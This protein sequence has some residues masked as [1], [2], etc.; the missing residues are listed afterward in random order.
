MKNIGKLAVLGAVLAA[1]S[2]FAFADQVV[3]ASYGLTTGYNPGT[4]T[5]TGNTA[6]EFAAEYLTGST[7]PTGPV[8][9][10]SSFTAV[11]TES[12]DLNPQTPIWNAALSG[13]SW[14]G[15]ATTAGPSPSGGPNTTVNP[16]YGYYEFTT[17]LLSTVAAGELNVYADDTTEVLLYNGST[18]STLIPLGSLGSDGHCADD[19][20]TCTVED[21]VGFSAAAGDELIFIVEQ[22]G[23]V[24]STGLD[25]SGVDFDVTVAPEPSSLM[26]LGTGLIGAAGMLFR[27]RRVIA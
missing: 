18:Y 27:R 5:T 2:S 22:A 13:S 16:A 24:T 7:A 26:L 8:P 10:L 25:P 12:Y 23:D 14:V 20:P 21:S 9:S 4:V 3:M 15:I 1:S 17:T 19:A 11:G 6:M